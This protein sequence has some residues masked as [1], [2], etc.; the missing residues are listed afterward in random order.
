MIPPA[1]PPDAKEALRRK[2]AAAN[3]F[4]PGAGLFLLGHRRLG[5]G[6]AAV[7]LVA[8]LAVIGV[9]V[10][11]YAN[12]LKVALDPDVLR[13]DQ[14]EH[15]GSGFHLPWILS[16]AALGVAVY[17]FGTLAFLRLRKR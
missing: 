7:F 3:V 5:A 1:L 13:G 16:L 17:V 14:L 15:V 8:F 11:G 2:A 12:Y 9:F 10:A 4:L 6:I